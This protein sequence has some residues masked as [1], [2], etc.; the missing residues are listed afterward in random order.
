MIV[1]DVCYLVSNAVGPNDTSSD[2]IKS[3]TQ[4]TGRACVVAGGIVFLIAVALYVCTRSYE[5]RDYHYGIPSSAALLATL[6]NPLAG[7]VVL[8]ATGALE[9]S[10]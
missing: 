5:A 1:S 4:R 3:L 7:Y 9:Y 10:S 2:L 6:M 8:M